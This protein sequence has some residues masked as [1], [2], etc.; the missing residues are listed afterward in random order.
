MPTD[1]LEILKKLPP[2]CVIGPTAAKSLAIE[3][4]FAIHRGV[5]GYTP[6][7][8]CTDAFADKFNAEKGVTAKQIEAMQVGSMFGWHVPGADPDSY[9]DGPYWP[10]RSDAVKQREF[11]RNAKAGG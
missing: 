7:P 10:D 5:P 4:G 2:V 6:M 9:D 8:S 11:K 3:T 1:V